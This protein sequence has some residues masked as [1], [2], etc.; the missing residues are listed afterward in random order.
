MNTP[1]STRLQHT[2]RHDVQ[3]THAYAIQDSA[4]L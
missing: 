3:S 2:I 4:G 1:L